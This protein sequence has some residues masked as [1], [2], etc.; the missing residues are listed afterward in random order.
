MD[1]SA[2]AAIPS[3][4]EVKGIYYKEMRLKMVDYKRVRSKEN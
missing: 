1:Q 4:K 2:K 3:T